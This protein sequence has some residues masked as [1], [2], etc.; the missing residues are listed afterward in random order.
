MKSRKQTN[1]IPHCRPTSG[2]LH[3]EK[4]KDIRLFMPTHTY[5]WVTKMAADT[6]Q[7]IPFVLSEMIIAQQLIRQDRC[8]S[9]EAAARPA[10]PSRLGTPGSSQLS[11]AP[12]PVLEGQLFI[13]ILASRFPEDN[14]AARF[15]QVA[16]LS[17]II[18]ET[19]IG[20]HPTAKTI[21]ARSLYQQ[22]AVN[23]LAALLSRRGLIEI[24]SGQ[25]PLRGKSPNVF[26]VRPDALEIFAWTHLQA[27]D[28]PISSPPNPTTS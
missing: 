21:A 5:D 26:S 4:T 3:T 6:R 25:S 11:A 20:I 28:Q 2:G 23:R 13:A 18:A 15:R 7:R 27:T 14:G 9:R 19:A 16:V 10:E 12:N 22:S 8:N 24:H 1:G 17:A